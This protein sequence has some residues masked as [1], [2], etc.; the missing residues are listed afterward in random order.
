VKTKPGA[1]RAPTARPVRTAIKNVQTA[2]KNVQTAVTN[3]TKKPAEKLKDAP[4]S[5][6]E[7]D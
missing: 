4:A 3:L 5:T 2:I 1:H 6:N 7:S